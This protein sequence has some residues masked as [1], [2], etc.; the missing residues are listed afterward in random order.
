MQRLKLEIKWAL[1]FIAVSLLWML[2]ERLTGLHDEHIDQH[3]LYTNLVALPAILI[4]FL[5]LRQM[6][7]KYYAGFMTYR[8][9]FKTGLIITLLVCL[10]T[11]LSQ[12]ITSSII[13]PDYFENV[14]AYAVESGEMTKSEAVAYFNLSNYMLQSTIFTAFAGLITTAIMA[15]VLRKNPS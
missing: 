9:G 3:A 14:S 10:L 12:Y 5:A 8:Q 7:E 13:T 15:L 2:L 4:Y 1:I 11:P 6:R